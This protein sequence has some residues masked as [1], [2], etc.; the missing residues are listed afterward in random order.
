MPSTNATEDWVVP[1]D[2]DIDPVTGTCSYGNM[3]RV[4]SSVASAQG[5]A[6]ASFA[7]ASLSADDVFVDLGCGEGAVVRQAA[8]HTNCR[9]CYGV[10]IMP[11]L[12]EAAQRAST[13]LKPGASAVRCEAND[14]FTVLAPTFLATLVAADVESAARPLAHVVLYLYNTPS[15]MGRADLKLALQTVVDL[16][17]RVVSAV[18]HIPCWTPYAEDPVLNVR[19]YRCQ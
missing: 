4:G 17:A 16:G 18:Y 8:E 14:I 19:L 13:T 2:D 3:N 6:A 5:V 12:I 7:L 11:H 10:D 9:L 1:F 15:F